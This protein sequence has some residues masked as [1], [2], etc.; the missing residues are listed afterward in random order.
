HWGSAEWCQCYWFCIAELG[1]SAANAGECQS[2]ST[3]VIRWDEKAG[4]RRDAVRS[5]VID[6][7]EAQEIKETGNEED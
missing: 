6:A 3:V 4:L 2:W 5:Q 7:L 1:S